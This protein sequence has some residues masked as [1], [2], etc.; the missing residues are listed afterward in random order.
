MAIGSA[1]LPVVAGCADHEEKTFLKTL[2]FEP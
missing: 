1:A 2:F